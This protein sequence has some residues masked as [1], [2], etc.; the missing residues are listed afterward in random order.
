MTEHAD[1]LAV[2]EV[3]HQEV[4]ALAACR[5]TSTDRGCRARR[6]SARSSAVPSSEVRGAG[7]RDDDGD[8]GRL[9]CG[10]VARAGTPAWPPAPS[11]RGRP[12]ARAPT[13]TESSAPA[14]SAPLADRR[15][16]RSGSCAA[17]PEEEGQH[18]DGRDA[19]ASSR[20]RSPGSNE[21][22]R[23]DPL[24][25][26]GASLGQDSTVVGSNRAER[27]VPP[28]AAS[29]LGLRQPERNPRRWPPCHRAIWLDVNPPHRR[30]P[31]HRRRAR[32]PAGFA[33]PG[34]ARARGRASRSRPG[35]GRA[36]RARR[37]PGRRR[38]S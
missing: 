12:R 36:G 5:R 38:P 13:R 2:V 28:A 22:T 27:R 11:R 24:P 18:R 17:A 29:T 9:R 7:G 16:R 6:C 31:R 30:P 35:A 15:H 19:A 23:G 25:L 14:R 20:L 33:G 21:D 8:L 1:R 4:G 10:A 32:R 26:P 34:G 37:R 3:E